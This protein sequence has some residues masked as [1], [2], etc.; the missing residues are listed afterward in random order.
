MKRAAESRIDLGS[1]NR[2]GSVACCL[3]YPRW[4][5]PTPP[6]LRRS[7]RGRAAPTPSHSASSRICLARPSRLC[8]YVVTDAG[9]TR[10]AAATN[11]SLEAA[12]ALPPRSRTVRRPPLSPRRGPSPFPRSAGLPAAHV[13]PRWRRPRPPR[14]LAAPR[15][16]GAPDAAGGRTHP[17]AIGRVSR[18]P[19]GP[20]PGT[21]RRLRP[22]G[23]ARPRRGRRPPRAPR[24]RFGPAP[25]HDPGRSGR[26]A[27]SRG[28]TARPADASRPSPRPPLATGADG[29]RPAD[30]ATRSAGRPPSRSRS[31]RGAGGRRLGSRARG[32]P[33]D[34][35]GPGR[36]VVR[37]LRAE[38][39][40]R[41]PR[42]GA[43]PRK[44]VRP[45]APC[46]PSASGGPAAPSCGRGGRRTAR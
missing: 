36:Q 15:P 25:R 41:I 45:W 22:S 20:P 32:P 28:P 5:G 9:R 40:D 19:S 33:R 18:R 34:P 6:R 42:I 44:P 43:A 7:R 4:T 1:I 11:T 17:T 37:P 2:H 8:D 10:P 38:T 23:P 14:P 21:G 26:P 27:S 12:P 39:L 31:H 16:Q 46:P 24:G 3:R 13:R 35:G 30:R 29:A